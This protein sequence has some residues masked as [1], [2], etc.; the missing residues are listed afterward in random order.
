VILLRSAEEYVSSLNT[1]RAGTF[2][3]RRRAF[4]GTNIYASSPLWSGAFRHDHY[5]HNETLPQR[6]CHGQAQT[7]SLWMLHSL[8]TVRQA[9]AWGQWRFPAP[10][11]G[12]WVDKLLLSTLR[13]F[14]QESSTSDGQGVDDTSCTN[15][16]KS[17][18]IAPE[19]GHASNPNHSVALR[20]QG[21][22]ITQG[23]AG[24]VFR[25]CLPG[26][27]PPTAAWDLPGRHPCQSAEVPRRNAINNILAITGWQPVSVGRS[28]YAGLSPPALKC[29]R[30]MPDI[31]FVQASGC[32]GPTPT[33]NNISNQ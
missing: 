6:H 13:N 32:A 9:V 16:L 15:Q 23:V 30:G 18:Q 12:G 24:N 8:I 31:A 11:W 3:R 20:V 28:Q 26:G 22:K 29:I 27:G 1:F 33:S 5:I 17:T 4:F 7:A 25:G 19:D 21:R 10:V 2:Q 14:M